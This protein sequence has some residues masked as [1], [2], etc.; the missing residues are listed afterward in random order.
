VIK[1]TVAILI[2]MILVVALFPLE[3]VSSSFAKERVIILFKDRSGQEILQKQ[4]IEVLHQ[5]TTIPMVSAFLSRSEIEKLI[6]YP[7][8][9]SV[10]KDSLIQ[11]VAEEDDWGIEQDSSLVNIH[12]QTQDWGIER[13]QAPS[14][15]NQG[16]TGEGFKIAVIDTGIASH[17]DLEIHGGVSFVTGTDSYEDDHGHGTH[18]AGI[19]AARNNEIGVVGIVP[20]AKLYAVKVLDAKGSAFISDVIAGIDWAIENDMDIINLSLGTRLSYSVFKA[21]VDKANDQ[22]ILVVAA[23]GNDGTP[24]GRGDNVNYPARYES[25]I[26]VGAITPENARTAFSSTGNAV[27][28]SAPGDNVV[29]TVLNDKYAKMSGTSMAAPYVSGQLALLKQ[30]HPEAN[31]AKLRS[32]LH[33]YVSDLGLQGKDPHFGY[34]LI[35]A[36]M[37]REW[38][39]PHPF[40]DTSTHWAAP[41]ILQ[42]HELGM[43]NGYPDQTFKPEKQ[44]TRAEFAKF[45]VTALQLPTEEEVSLSFMDKQTI[46]VWAKQYVTAATDAGLILGYKNSQGQSYFNPNAWI[47]RAEMA[48]ILSRALGNSASSNQTLHFKDADTVPNWAKLAVQ[49]T[50]QR[51]LING[52]GDDTF[53]PLDH[54]TRA[55]TVKVIKILLDTTHTTRR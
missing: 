43:V 2:G 32:M 14:A 36:L 46:P 25:V 3:Q 50:V 11:W 29:S 1:K 28:V 30:A 17:E 16:Y 13:I 53:R 18:V 12:K 10:E 51:G 44:V 39:Q 42:L 35:Q 24:D 34:G 27:E 48:V 38:V 22:G 19:I 4:N 21:V 37:Q 55:Q 8:V 26:A 47:T 15:W 20:E 41:F 7:G 6:N 54:V 5:S 33:S 9:E 23:A 49:L 31:V 40:V 52:F 45:I